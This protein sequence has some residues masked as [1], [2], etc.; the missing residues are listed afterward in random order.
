MIIRSSSPVNVKLPKQKKGEALSFEGKLA[1]VER[2]DPHLSEN[3]ILQSVFFEKQVK[4]I[5]LFLRQN[6]IFFLQ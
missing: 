5:V 6:G 3:L 1:T 2:E 4:F